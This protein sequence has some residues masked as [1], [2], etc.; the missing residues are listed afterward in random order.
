MKIALLSLVLLLQ[1][2]PVPVQA[3]VFQWIDSAGVTHFSDD[4]DSI[5][6]KYR[7]KAKKLDISLEPSEPAPQK[8]P[9]AQGAE[10]KAAKAR[11]QNFGGQSEQWWRER[12]S[13]LRGEL[14]KLQKDLADKQIKLVELRRKRWIYMRTQDREA[15]NGMQDAITAEEEQ[16]ASLQKQIADLD[17]RATSAAVP[18]EWR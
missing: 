1:F 4:R 3:A 6:K 11:S 15:V 18:M 12:F 2:F 9:V 10:P 17:K 13:A 8:L 5:P 7:R 16:V 14:E